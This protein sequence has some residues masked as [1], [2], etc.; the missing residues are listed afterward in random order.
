MNHLGTKTLETG[1]LILRPFRKTDLED[2]Y[3]NWASNSNVTKYLT[4]PT[5]TSM[6][7]TKSVLDLWV[8]QYEDVK[9]Y[10]WCIEWKAN[11]QAIGSLGIVHMEKELNAVE[12]GYCIGEE[13]WNKGITSEALQEVIKFLFEKVDC[14][15]IAARH[16][17][18]NPNSGKV[19]KKSGLLYE[20]T[21]LQAG[22]N[23]TGICDMV[24]YGITR[25]IYGI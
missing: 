6:E 11:K 16:D 13:Y 14:N 21:L 25:K 1:R 3:H 15:R 23:N 10:Q 9:N 19:M 2:M 4:W 5:H 7:I 22:K 17:V 18:C 20:G 12:I 24:V 8:S